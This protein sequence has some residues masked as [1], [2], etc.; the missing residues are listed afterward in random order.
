MTR[1][2]NRRERY[3]VYGGSGIVVLVL[4]HWL[5]VSPMIEARER[6]ARTLASKMRGVEEMI[7]LSSE[8]QVIEGRAAASKSRFAG[9]R[10]NF[11]LFSF[12]DQL[13]GETAVKPHIAFMKPS[14]STPK[15]SL[16]KI[17][18][19]EMKFQNII[20]EQLT[21]YLHKVETSR[22]QVYVKRLSITTKQP[23]FVDALLQVETSEI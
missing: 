1:K 5:I 18:Q 17:A 7:S 21:A 23:G 13:A 16:Y 19:V 3:A 9:R 20:M 4:L 10:A 8:Y 12:L 2:L 15:G 22:N 6:M 14:T 11:T